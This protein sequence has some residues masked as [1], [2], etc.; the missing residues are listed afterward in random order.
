MSDASSRFFQARKELALL[1][2]PASRNAR[3]I[4]SRKFFRKARKKPEYRKHSWKFPR[5][6]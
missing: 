1:S 2:I 5:G 3:K 4:A 6:A